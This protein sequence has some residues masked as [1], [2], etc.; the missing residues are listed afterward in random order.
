LR[1]TFCQ[2]ARSQTQ[3]KERLCRG[4][5]HMKPYGYVWTKQNHEPKLFW[6]E[7]H[8]KDVQ[9]QFGGEVVAVYK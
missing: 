3:A 4:E 7:S 1:D 8:A 6:I 5:E 2:R 9:K